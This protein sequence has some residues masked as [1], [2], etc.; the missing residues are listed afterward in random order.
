MGI[1][2]RHFS[3]VL[4][5]DDPCAHHPTILSGYYR[6]LRPPD[7]LQS[8]RPSLRLH[9]AVAA[10]RKVCSRIGLYRYV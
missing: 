7:P 4:A 2:E 5:S 3:T 8:L 9:V 10:V 1:L 6:R